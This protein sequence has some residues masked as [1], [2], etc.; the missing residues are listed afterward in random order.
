MGTPVSKP[1]PTPTV[2]EAVAL[3]A[4]AM[5]KVTVKS[6]FS[7]EK[8]NYISGVVVGNG[9]LAIIGYY[10]SPL[11]NVSQYNFSPI[12]M[13]LKADGRPPEE[14]RGKFAENPKSIKFPD[15]YFLQQIYRSVNRTGPKELTLSMEFIAVNT[16]NDKKSFIYTEIRKELPNGPSDFQGSSF[17]SGCGDYITG[18]NGETTFP[19]GANDTF[20]VVCPVYV[21][22]KITNNKTELTPTAPTPT[23]SIPTAPIPTA[24]TPTTPTPTAPTPTAPTPTAPGDNNIKILIIICV[25]VLGIYL[26]TQNT[27]ASN[28]VQKVPNNNLNNIQQSSV[29][30]F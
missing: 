4:A 6:V 1:T 2:T 16:N 13:T 23:A 8:D 25:I 17:R 29:N 20:D 15:G 11:G 30:Y 27:P 26:Y 18:I 14:E 19:F 24:P 9:A 10:T 22:S 5:Q 7:V 3:I 28:A 12:I 21:S